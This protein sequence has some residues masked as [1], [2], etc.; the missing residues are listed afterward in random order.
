MSM[1]DKW[2]ELSLRDPTSFWG[3]YAKENLF[4][5]KTWNKVFDAT[6][7]PT[8]AYTWFAG[9]KCNTCYNAL[10][11]HVEAGNGEQVALYYDSPVTQQK[12]SFTYRQTRDEVARLAGLLQ[13]FGVQAG[14]RVV[15][16]MP[17]IAQ[18]VMAML[19][20]ARIGAIHSTVF[21]GFAALQ[22]AKRIDHAQPKVI[23][24]ASCG[25][26]LRKIIDYY[27]L[28]Q[29]ALTLCEHQPQ[30]CIIY[31]REQQ[32][33]S[34]QSDKHV[35]WQEH[36]PHARLVDCV[37][38]DAH[39]PQYILYTS[40]TTGAPK[41]VVRDTAGHM[42]AL[43]WTMRYLYAMQ[44]R[45]VFWSASDIGWVVGH[46]YIV[47]GPLLY[48]CSSVVFEGKPV[49]TPDAGAFWRVVEDYKVNAL[50][51]APTTIRAI[52]REDAHGALFQ[53]YNTGSLRSI[54]LAGERADP[55]TVL[56]A[57]NQLKVAVIDNWWQTETG[58]AIA[59]N[60]QVAE[61][62]PV[63]AGAAG[64]AMPG[65]QVEIL[66]GQSG[67]PL[68]SGELGEVAIKLPMPPGN[69]YTLW[70]DHDRYTKGYLEK[71]PGYYRSGD[72]GFI[73]QNGYIS[74]MARNDGIINVAG[75]RITTGALEEAL[76]GLSEVAECAVVG[77]EDSLKGFVPIGFAVLKKGI[78]IDHK[79]ISAKAVARVR[80]RIGP[81][82]AFQQLVVVER[83]PKT[84]SGKIL[85][86]I[87]AA[88]V[89]NKPFDV[90]P[91]IDD[92]AILDE[93]AVAIQHQNQ[94]KNL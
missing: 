30:Q 49:G 71:F 17:M 82:A 14:D 61:N 22:L 33:A 9:A 64:K 47:Y 62:I 78:T 13:S 89:N 75:H 45:E 32:L 12:Q 85:R 76:A 11:K 91:T 34:L 50:F 68:A 3:D 52:K 19:A 66:S 48:G 5:H 16:Y 58:W 53:K 40:G 2:R 74:I 79:E 44:P 8:R 10:D 1:Q 92:P 25:I 21:G 55:D 69:F 20:C 31:Q 90:P 43:H 18:G 70:R 26:E 36:V 38:V 80:K 88:I 83:L 86:A 27:D 84:R 46:S 65:Y 63:I 81:V 72:A 56:W 54:F 24:S 57:Q 67:A 6:S 35:I 41:G 60:C 51:T 94:K 73:D 37:P 7:Q 77:A 93:I 28:L 87:I 23:I 39:H 42:V 4:W 29:Q 15:I 59:G